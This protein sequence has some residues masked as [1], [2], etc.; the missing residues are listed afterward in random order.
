MLKKI[1]SFSLFEKH[2]MKKYIAARWWST[3][4][5]FFFQFHFSI[6]K[7]KNV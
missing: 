3:S 5:Q 6:L 1:L 2:Q 4:K 7:T